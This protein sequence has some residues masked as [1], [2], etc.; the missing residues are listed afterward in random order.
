M[1]YYRI[2]IPLTVVLKVEEGVIT[3]CVILLYVF[4]A[5]QLMHI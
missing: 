1:R 5:N 3:S 2:I 4:N